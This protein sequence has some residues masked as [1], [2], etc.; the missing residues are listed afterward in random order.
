MNS[1][2]IYQQFLSVHEGDVSGRATF[3]AV[4]V[5]EQSESYATSG[6]FLM[7]ALKIRALSHVS[8]GLSLTE[9]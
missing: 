5:P 8:L 9:E 7:D 4:F 6:Q 2:V 1:Q 3:G